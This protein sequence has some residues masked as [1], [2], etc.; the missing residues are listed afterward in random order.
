MGFPFGTSYSDMENSG[1]KLGQVFSFHFGDYSESLFLWSRKNNISGVEVEQVSFK[2][3]N[4]YG[5]FSTAIVVKETNLKNIIDV[6]E[7]NIGQKLDNKTEDVCFDHFDET[8]CIT[9]SPHEKNFY[10]KLNN[11][12]IVYISGG[13][14]KTWNVVITD[15]DES[16]RA[17][18]RK[19]ALAEYV[20]AF[21]EMRK[22]L[23]RFKD[24]A[25]FAQVGF[26]HSSPYAGWL[27]KVT[28]ESNKRFLVAIDGNPLMYADLMSLGLEYVSSKGRETR[29][30]RFFE[31]EI[32]KAL[33]AAK[34]L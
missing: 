32:D 29:S 9:P 3:N 24:S 31:A 27:N 8:I 15:I 33:N 4:E 10:I 25:D 19:D 16:F 2:I 28:R 22:E 5:M 7:K 13:L 12:I 6:I 17:N 14:N 11:G 21:S 30:S 18:E 34:L 23:M 20:D 1:A 26:N